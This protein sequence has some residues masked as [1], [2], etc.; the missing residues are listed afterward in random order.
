MCNEYGENFVWKYEG[1]RQ[2]GDQL[3]R[4]ENNTKLN[5]KGINEKGMGYV[6]TVV[7]TVM[8]C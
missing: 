3:C 6:R 2:L 7:T 1:K 8:S 5:L 4:W